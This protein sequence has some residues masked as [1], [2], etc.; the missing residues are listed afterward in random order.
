M[1]TLSDR[2]TPSERGGSAASNLLSHSRSVAHARAMRAA[3][4][5]LADDGDDTVCTSILSDFP[6]GG[7]D[8]GRLAP[9]VITS[10]PQAVR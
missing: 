6:K 8:I 9:L 7:A 5:E 4:A 2:C 1:S 3:D 10:E